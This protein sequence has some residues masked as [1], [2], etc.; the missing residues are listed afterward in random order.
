MRERALLLAP[1]PALALAMG[2]ALATPASADPVVMAAGDI[3]CA[4]GHPRTGDECR[5]RDTSDLLVAADPN[6]VLAL[7]DNQYETG[8]LR[9]FR[10]SYDQAWGRVKRRI[11]PVPGN[12]EYLTSGADGY[13]DYFGDRAGGTRRGY[14]SFDL[15]T[16]QVI[17]LNSEIR[18]G[19]SSRQIEWLRKKLA[20]N[21]ADCTLAYFHTPRF[22][23]GEHGNSKRMKPMWQKLFG[24]RVDVVL[25]GHD[26]DYERFAKLEPDGERNRERGIRQ[27]VV[28]TGGSHLRP[29]GDIHRHSAERQAHTFGVLELELHEGSYDWTFVPEAGET[30]TDTGADDCH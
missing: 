26:H 4:P 18:V 12:H 2:L 5:H 20:A 29:F 27:F 21:P 24:A 19:R 3:A 10:N 9:E 23:S 11:R 28:G 15:G 8:R 14:Y 22:S 13:F 6:K 17:A 1:I 25:N 16:W 30:Y 7:G